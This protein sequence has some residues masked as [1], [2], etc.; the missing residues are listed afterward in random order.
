MLYWNT[1]CFSPSLQLQRWRWLS[2][3]ELNLWP[4]GRADWIYSIDVPGELAWLNYSAYHSVRDARCL[5][6][7]DHDGGGHWGAVVSSDTA[8]MGS[9]KVGPPCLNR[10]SKCG[11]RELVQYKNTIL[12]LTHL[13]SGISCCGKMAA[14]YWWGPRLIKAERVINFNW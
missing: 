1:S 5:A 14:L 10:D 4:M 2:Q 3:T 7:I 9:E 13:Q 8:T 11:S 6:G 12:Q